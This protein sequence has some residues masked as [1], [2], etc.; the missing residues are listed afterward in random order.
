MPLIQK[1]KD[2][3]RYPSTWPLRCRLWSRLHTVANR[4]AWRFARPEGPEEGLALRID[5]TNPW[6]R[7]NDWCAEGWIPWWVEECR[8]RQEVRKPACS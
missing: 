2:A 6:W 8:R 4:L 1:K 5:K 7:L 3:W